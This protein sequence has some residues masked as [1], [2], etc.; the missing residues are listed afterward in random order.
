MIF[1]WVCERAQVTELLA[2]H[3]TPPRDGV[4]QCREYLPKG[5][6]GEIE[7]LWAADPTE[8]FIL[9]RSIVVEDE[10][11]KDFS[12]W[13]ST[14]FRHIR[15]FTAHCRIMGRSMAS[16]VRQS[17]MSE[18]PERYRSADIAV[19]IAETV[20]YSIG[21]SSA[22]NTP[23][24]YCTRTLSHVIAQ[25]FRRYQGAWEG[26]EVLV[27]SVRDGWLVSRERAGH[28]ALPLTADQVLDVWNTIFSVFERPSRRRKV[29]RLVSEALASVVEN[30]KIL[31]QEW[32]LLARNVDTAD[33]LWN[34]LEGPREGRVLAV[35]KALPKLARGPSSDRKT[36]AFLA[37]YLASRIQ[38]GTLEHFRVLA[39]VSDELRDSF[40][41][42]G[43][44]AGLAPE[45]SVE[46]YDQGLGW[47]LRR[48]LA[49][50]YF[51][52]QRPQ[53]DISLT[54]FALLTN[55]PETRRPNFQTKSI[56]SLDVELV[57]FVT[58]N[59]RWGDAPKA[60]DRQVS[61]Q[62]RQATL[63]A[64]NEVSM[65]EVHELLRRVEESSHNLNTIRIAVEKA[66]GDKTPARSRKRRK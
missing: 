1:Q 22:S 29:D 33:S 14:Y 47:L 44:C 59:V 24:A 26:D 19:V 57:P 20:A 50:D 3:T 61:A 65:H 64:E 52:L 12:A 28:D 37:G 42:Y 2:G 40:L 49:R 63:F 21:T 43:A 31:R 27:D 60:S 41:W 11:L 51:W 5:K 55:S 16:K 58:T 39:S 35:E 30:G 34:S 53:A 18:W 46:E 15:P 62:S 45:T 7:L 66:F 6:R 10:E 56:G 54:E 25:A 48:E 38:P 9:P 36:R 23:Y 32:R 13:M 4:V 8:R 17:G